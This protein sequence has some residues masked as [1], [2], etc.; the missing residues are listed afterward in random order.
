MDQ[1]GHVVCNRVRLVALPTGL[2]GPLGYHRDPDDA[3]HARLP[4][5]ARQERP[6]G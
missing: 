4:S 3:L 6:C 5:L 1:P 2:L